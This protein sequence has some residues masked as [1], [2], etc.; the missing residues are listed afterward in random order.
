MNDVIRIKHR[1]SNAL[2]GIKFYKLGP[3]IN[4][5][6]NLLLDR[7]K[8]ATKNT[9][10]PNLQPLRLDLLRGLPNP[11]SKRGNVFHESISSDSQELTDLPN[12]AARIPEM[13]HLE[14]K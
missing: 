9:F 6:R 1:E 5:A 10:P 12:P 4:P 11:F 3:P 13:V 8:G 2:A 7:L 14:P